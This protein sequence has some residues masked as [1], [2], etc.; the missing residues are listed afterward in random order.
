MSV[1]DPAAR[2]DD[3]SP[4]GDRDAPAAGAGARGR[5]ALNDF[6]PR[7]GVLV[8]FVVMIIVFSIAKPDT[9]PTWDNTKNILTAAAPA[10]VLAAGLTVP[11]VM[12]DF[13]LSFGAVA[14]LAGGTAV[15]LMSKESSGWLAAILAALAL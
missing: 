1:D 5:F 3:A 7:Y 10:L 9:F 11:L 14:S 13:D 4:G 6:L 2:P 8:A 12:Q 15:V